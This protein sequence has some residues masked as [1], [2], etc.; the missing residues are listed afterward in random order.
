MSLLR[1]KE[2]AKSKSELGN[3]INYVHNAITQNKI[4]ELTSQ[5]SFAKVFQPVTS[6]LDDVIDSNLISSVPQKR[7]RPRKKGEVPDY[8]IDIDDEVEDMNLD[9]LFEEEPIPP[10][11]DKQLGLRPPPYQPP[12]PPPG[13]PPSPPPGPP[14]SPP[15]EYD[16]DEGIDYSIKD[17]DQVRMLLDEM[18]MPNFEHVDYTLGQDIMND[19]RATGYLR[20]NIK[21]A[22]QLSKEL[23]YEKVKATKK[24]NNEEMSL[25]D[26]IMTHRRVDQQRDSLKRLINYLEN[27]KKLYQKGKGIKGRGI[28]KK[29]EKDRNKIKGYKAHVTKKYNGGAISESDKQI[30]NKLLDDKMTALNKYIKDHKKKLELEKKIKGRRKQ[31]GGNVVFFNDVKQL[32]KKLELIIGEVIA[33]N[34][35]IQMRNTGVSILDMLLKMAKINRSQYNKLYNQYFKA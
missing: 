5:E 30:M 2:L 14:P 17:E 8:G 7:K 21:N 27:K 12:S 24:Y 34:T 22:K 35:S 10:E 16:Y 4:G 1:W 15:P 32:L 29:L 31:R 6:K 11:P 3:K 25:F 13:P 19:K 28:L 26:K 9:D 23:V 20:K 18:Q 33:G